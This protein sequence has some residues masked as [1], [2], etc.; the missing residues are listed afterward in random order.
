MRPDPDKVFAM[1]AEAQAASDRLNQT[2]P[3]WG[4]SPW[5]LGGPVDGEWWVVRSRGVIADD[6]AS[7]ASDY[8]RTFCEI[9]RRS[10]HNR[11]F[12][13]D[14]EGI[15]IEDVHLEGGYPDTR[16]VMLFRAAESRKVRFGKPTADCLFGVRTRIW[17]AEYANPEAEAGF[18]AVYL[19]EFL[20]TNARAF[21]LRGARPCD[22]NAINWLR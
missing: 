22:P 14:A 6:L 5:Y 13:R 8:E 17:P 21:V 2:P 1:R 7:E 9:I 12:W 19:A 11:D 18:F 15:Q 16:L 20:G 4:W 3:E 10:S